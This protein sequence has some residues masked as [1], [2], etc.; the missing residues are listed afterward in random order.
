VEL[1]SH[2]AP[3]P[4]PP[5]DLVVIGASA[6]G[7]EALKH[8]VSGLGPELPAA[9]CVVLHISP[10]SPSALARILQRAGPLPCHEAMDGERLRTGEIIVA[11]PDRHL[12]IEDGRARL[13]VGPRENGHRPSVDTL[14]RSAAEDRDGRVIGVVL[15][16]NRDDG[17]AGLATIKSGGGA[18]IVQDPGEALYDSMP[19]SA[20]ANVKVDA[21]AR[22]TEIAATIADM[23]RNPDYRQRPTPIEAQDRPPD[24]VV[25]PPPERRDSHSA[26]P[27]C[28]GV[29]VEESEAGI[30]R[31]RCMIGHRYSPESLADAQALAVERALEAAIRALQERSV[32][33][34]RMADQCVRR[35]QVASARP[36]RERASSARGE[37]GVV[38][39]VYERAT[40]S[41]LRN[42]EGAGDATLERQ[43]QS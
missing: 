1:E 6:G 20:I 9:V 29:L 30:P 13:S 3:K 17:S 28:G 31:W 4:N 7:I 5:R 10:S 18:T 27:D 12:V 36:F 22:S 23:L 15:S 11:P 2:P 8:L 42:D 40:A 38:R 41:A 34:E 32:L 19:S 16:G 37:A 21:V 14:F 43:I 26:C 24:D 33:M 25:D 35:A 39:K